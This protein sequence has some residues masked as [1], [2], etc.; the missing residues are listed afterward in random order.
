MVISITRPL[1][2]SSFFSS[3]PYHLSVCFQPWNHSISAD[4]M[5]LQINY[6]VSPS[7]GLTLRFPKLIGGKMFL[8]YSLANCYPYIS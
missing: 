4:F 7:E 8:Y 3:N 6:L 1:G 5:P 2:V